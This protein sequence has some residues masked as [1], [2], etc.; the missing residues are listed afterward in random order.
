MPCTQGRTQ[1]TCHSSRCTH[2]SL[3]CGCLQTRLHTCDPQQTTTQARWSACTLNF[4]VCG[5][6]R[7]PSPVRVGKMHHALSVAAG[8]LCKTLVP[9]VHV[10]TSYQQPC[11]KANS[12]CRSGQGGAPVQQNPG[13]IQ[14]SSCSVLAKHPTYIVPSGHSTA[15]QSTGC[16]GAVAL[17][18]SIWPS[19]AAFCS[20][21]D[22]AKASRL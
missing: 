8:A 2:R 12:T 7:V 17:P 19:Q 3:A 22:A 21:R 1:L 18:A 13:G 11:S 10:R 16:G 20:G 15:F 14:T 9:A 5:T 4:H 6:I